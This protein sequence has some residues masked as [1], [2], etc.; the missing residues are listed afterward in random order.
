MRTTVLATE[1]PMPKTSPATDGPAENVSDRHAEA[2][3]DDALRQRAWHGNAPD[4]HELL[5]VKLQADAKHQEDD[6]DLGELFRHVTIGHEA[7]RVRSD[8]Q[9]RDEITDDG[10]E[11]DA[12]RREAKDKGGAEAASQG[13]DQVEGVHSAIISG[14]GARRLGGSRSSIVRSSV[15]GVR[16]ARVV[17]AVAIG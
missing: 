1:S 9:A 2:S 16:D 3:R 8:E 6:A 10:G 13:E 5:D 7:W 4:G 15:V 12:V 14:L 17:V 11:P